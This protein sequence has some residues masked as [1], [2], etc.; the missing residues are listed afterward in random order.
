MW[1]VTRAEVGIVLYYCALQA[2]NLFRRKTGRKDF[3]EV[4]L[5]KHVPHGERGGR[6]WA[7]LLHSARGAGLSASVRACTHICLHTGT[8]VLLEGGCDQM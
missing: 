1:P 2:L 5:D 8:L 3:F 4:Q 6:W 7:M